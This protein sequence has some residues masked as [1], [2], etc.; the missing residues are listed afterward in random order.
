MKALN[1]S[2]CLFCLLCTSTS[3]AKAGVN[4]KQWTTKNGVKVLFVA[5]KQ[6]P[7]LDVAVVFKA[8]SVYDGKQSGL[9]YLTNAMFHEGAGSYNV[10][11]LA[12]QFANVGAQFSNGIYQEVSFL[13]LRTLTKPEP[14]C[15]ALQ[16]FALVL[17]QPSFPQNSM[18]R[19]KKQ[20]LVNIK[21]S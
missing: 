9:A 21:R 5:A 6:I 12:D 19:L 3:F 1:L 17:N 20:T 8:G 11:Q 10:D 4:I 15:V 7:M 18:A 14:M 13:T 2:I 16:T